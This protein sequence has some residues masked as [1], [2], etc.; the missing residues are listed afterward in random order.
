[1]PRV[2]SASYPPMAM[3]AALTSLASALAVFERPPFVEG[4]GLALAPVRTRVAWQLSSE[5]AQSL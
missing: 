4:K 3:S 5:L 2:A 1:M